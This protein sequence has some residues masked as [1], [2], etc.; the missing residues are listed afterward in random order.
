MY[1][2]AFNTTESIMSALSSISTKD[3][4]VSELQTIK[5]TGDICTFVLEINRK[6][7]LAIPPPARL[8]TD[9]DEQYTQSL[10]QHK[11]TVEQKKI[12]VLLSGVKAAIV[13]KTLETLLK[14]D[15]KMTFDQ[16]VLILL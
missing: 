15:P 16:L 11:K 9:T 10:M 14:N 4:A 13:W 5:Q 1:L 7:H 6:V 2:K 3:Q 8:D 12:D